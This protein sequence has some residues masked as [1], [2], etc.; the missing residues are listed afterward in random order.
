MCSGTPD[1]K[2]G[3]DF[4]M[5]PRFGFTD[6]FYFDAS[7]IFNTITKFTLDDMNN[8]YQVGQ[9]N[10]TYSELFNV[11]DCNATWK[12][13]VNFYIES[14]DADGLVSVDWDN[15]VKSNEFYVHEGSPS[16]EWIN[17]PLV[18]NNGTSFSGSALDMFNMYYQADRKS[19]M[20]LTNYPIKKDAGTTT[21]YSNV[22]IKPSESYMLSF[23]AKDNSP[24]VG[25]KV[26][27]KTYAGTTLLNTHT[28]AH[29]ADINYTTFLCGWLDMFASGALTANSAEGTFFSNVDNYTVAIHA[30]SSASSG[31]EVL[32]STLYKFKLDRSCKGKG[33][34][35]FCFKNQLGGFDMVTSE[36]SYI[37]KRKSEF[38]R[39]QR[40]QGYEEWTNPMYFGESNWAGENQMLYSVTTQLM[41]K[42]LAQHFSEMMM[43]TQVYLDFNQQDLKNKVDSTNFTTILRNTPSYYKP[44]KLNQQTVRIINTND[45]AYKLK[46]D[47]AI[48]INQKTPRF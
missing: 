41:R 8:S 3:G 30:G 11:W 15:P 10:L 31:S 46:F 39:F 22:T 16:Q 9:S 1:Q 26:V 23:F 24:N 14:V 17:A 13:Y 25:Y 6:L 33:Y 38:E 20:F 28:N 7:E 5:A 40:T 34:L 37:T 32:N 44:I 21:P 48:S 47:F 12:V 27:V 29:T 19:K 18:T 4:R 35:R 43:S 36:G 42:E 45:N 2:V